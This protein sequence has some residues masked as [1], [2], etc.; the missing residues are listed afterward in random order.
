M[1]QDEVEGGM[2]GVEGR[3]TSSEKG[4]MKKPIMKYC[5]CGNLT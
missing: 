1:R 2:V 5:E 3:E 4:K